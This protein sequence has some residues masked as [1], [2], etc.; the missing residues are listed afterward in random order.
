[1]KINLIIQILIISIALVSCSEKGFEKAESKS[2]YL[3]EMESL[4]EGSLKNQLQ[5]DVDF[6]QN[7]V[8]EVSGLT[9]Y[10]TMSFGFGDGEMKEEIDTADWFRLADED[11]I[12]LDFQHIKDSIS[13]KQKYQLPN[14]TFDFDSENYDYDFSYLETNDLQYEIKEIYAQNKRLSPTKI[15]L[16]RADSLLVKIDYTFPKSLDTLVLDRSAKDSVLFKNHL[17]KIDT[18]GAERIGLKIPMDLYRKIKG[19]QGITENGIPVDHNSYSA[20]PVMGVN[21]VIIGELNSTKNVMKEAL[22]ASGKEEILKILKA[23][24]EPS[25]LYK[26]KIGA[27]L[28]DLNDLDQLQDKEFREMVKG[29]RAFESKYED[30]HWP[31]YQT[32]E[33]SYP[34]EI[35]AFNFYLS[36]SEETLS[37]N[38]IAIQYEPLEEVQ[39]FYDQ[40]KEKYGLMD[41]H[42]KIII[43][44]NYEK[45]YKKDSL[46]Y[47]EML[48]DGSMGYFLDLKNKKLEKLP[49]GVEFV[50][51]LKGNY[52]VFS[53]KN[54]YQGILKNRKDEILSYAYDGIDLVGNIFVLNRSKRGRSFYE[55]Q[56]IDGH[57]IEIS[58][59]ITDVSYYEGNPNVVIISRDGKFGLIDKSGKLSIPLSEVPIDMV[60]PEMVHYS[61]EQGYYD[62]RGLMDLKGKILV[63]PKY[64]DLGYLQE[65]RIFFSVL[66]EN[67]K[68]FGYLNSQGKEILPAV[69]TQATDFYQGAA[70]V[71]KDG[72]VYL[73]DTNGKVLKTMPSN[74][75]G[76][77]IDFK[78]DGTLTIYEVND[79]FY[80]SKGNLIQ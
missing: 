80:D 41:Q 51:N 42:S 13:T 66:K 74:P 31:L 32:V 19:V 3:A 65:G 72:K 46:F 62:L 56:T 14:S 78:N 9:F 76:N 37:L 15:G 22:N 68:Q 45:L 53:D 36:D 12:R 59:K 63:T 5:K 79:H 23:I 39:I 77:Y 17:I 60:S 29:Y 54:K 6:I 18:V 50:K 44:A 10:F 55:F 30:L 8:D 49:E 48:E 73:I 20:Y 24:S 4:S 38:T 70:M 52:A 16:E 71:E 43:P 47:Y 58:E 33:I 28:K 69:Y 67:R 27:Y 26:N 35:N 61:V 40:T 7:Q 25:F 21:P 11:S 2:E 57:K 75:D 34:N 1:M 64:L